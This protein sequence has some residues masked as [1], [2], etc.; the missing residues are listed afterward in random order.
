[1]PMNWEKKGKKLRMR[2]IDV[3][4]YEYDEQRVIVEAFFVDRRYQK[5]YVVTGE[6]SPRGIIHLLA[7]R[8]LIHCSNRMIEDVAVEMNTVPM[9]VCHELADSLAPLKG[10]TI[11]RGFMAK[12]KGLVGGD[13]GCT[14]LVELLQ[15]AAPAIVQGVNTHQHHEAASFNA[16]RTRT[17]L[18][19]LTN[20]CLAWKEDGQL[21][22][23]LEQHLDRQKG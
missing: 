13:R 14:H 17:M 1:M 3:T 2:R 22:K 15:A 6:V 18:N 7:V 12:V 5:T 21:V 11:A 10:L 9:E 8:L 4:T 19:R 20:T 23:E 16:E